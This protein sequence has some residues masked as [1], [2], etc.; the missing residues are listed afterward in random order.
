VCLTLGVLAAGVH[1]A[2]AQK[3]PK[4]GTVT[5]EQV[6]VALLWSASLG[7]GTLTYKGKSYDFVI[8][9]LGV[10]GIGASSLRATGEVYGLERVSDFEGVFAQAR[11]GYAVG[12]ES[13]GKLWLENPQGVGLALKADRKGLALTLGADGVVVKFK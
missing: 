7:G 11:S 12:D 2:Q 13:R 1:S 8:G 4:S 3:K 5:I 6:N 10:G 9:G